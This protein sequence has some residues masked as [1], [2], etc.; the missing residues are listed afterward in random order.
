MHTRE[1]GCSC[2]CDYDILKSELANSL[3]WPCRM[4]CPLNCNV[5]LLEDWRQVE[6]R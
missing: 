6:A 3:L 4:I 1:Y 2:S 5:E